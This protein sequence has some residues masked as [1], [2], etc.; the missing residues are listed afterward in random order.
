M[1]F[2]KRLKLNIFKLKLTWRFKFAH[3]PLCQNYS[4]QV[5]KIGNIY[6]CQGCTLIYSGLVIGLL[7]G[8]IF[9]PSFSIQIWAIIGVSLM[10]PTFVVQV[11][12]LPRMFKRIARFLN[13]FDLGAIFFSIFILPKWSHR[14][15]MIVSISVTYLAFRII[16]KHKRKE[17]D[18]CESCNELKTGK[19]CSGY[20]LRAEKELEY[21]KYA[22]QILDEEL[23]QLI[24]GKVNSAV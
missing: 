10:V 23:Q 4:D 16:H 1:K 20:K 5:F 2:L 8:I 3:H 22:E 18:L 11:V 12:K 6:L 15:I 24:Q 19:I 9:N 7:S 17:R 13:G 21:S 14:I